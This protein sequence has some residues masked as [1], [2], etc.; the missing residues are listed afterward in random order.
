[1][2]F[3][4]WFDYA[5]LVWDAHTVFTEDVSITKPTIT[6]NDFDMEEKRH[7]RIK[8]E[9]ELAMIQVQGGSSRSCIFGRCLC[10]QHPIYVNMY[11][12]SLAFTLGYKYD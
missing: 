12:S 5:W 10:R 3:A 11:Y 8:S 2:A 4:Q 6:S 9:M 7:H 1:M